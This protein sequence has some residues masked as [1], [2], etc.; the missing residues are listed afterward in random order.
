MPLRFGRQF[1]ARPARKS[2]SLR[3]TH[4]NGPGFR[5]RHGSKHRAIIPLRSRIRRGCTPAIRISLAR[6]EKWMFKSLLNFPIPIFRRPVLRI[7]VSTG[8]DKLQVFAIGHREN[9]NRKTRNG[10]F[11]RP[12]LVVP[13]ECSL[14]AFRLPERGAS[15]RDRAC[16]RSGD[17]LVSADG[18][19][20]GV[21]LSTGK[22]CNR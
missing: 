19:G 7:F 2:R 18:K 17:G 3:V 5:Q 22:L 11:L 8:L 16:R 10:N 15:R 20:C 21:F 12:K 6:P 4:V 1:L 9:I 13:S 14:P